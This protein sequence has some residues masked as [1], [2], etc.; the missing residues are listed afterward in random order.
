MPRLLSNRL[1]RAGLYVWLAIASL[2]V[3]GARAEDAVLLASTVPGYAPGMVISSTDRLSVPDGA[4]ATLLFQSGETLRLRGP[5]EGALGQQQPPA[6]TVGSVMF[7]DLFRMHGIDATVIGGT[8]S[9]VSARSQATL[10]DV[11]VDP[12]RSGT[13]C[14]EPATSVWI[15]RPAG[16]TGIYALRRKGNSRTLSWPTGAQR[17]EWPA[18]V[19]IED[20]SQFEITNGGAARTTVKFR[21]V[22]L[23]PG[24][25]RAR[26][27]AG[28]LAGCHDQ[29]D[30]ELRRF[31]RS[32]VSPE[33][34]ITTDHGRHP[35]Y[36]PGEPIGLTV[37]TST[38]GYVYCIATN[39]DGSAEPIFPAGAVDGAQLHGS[40]PL[41][42]PGRR[43]PNGLIATTATQQIRCW[44]ADRDIT[45]ELPHAV[46]GAPSTRLPDQF[47]SDLDGLFGRV[48]GTRTATDLLTIKA[49]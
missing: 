1:G 27:A 2:G 49:E 46:L 36:R 29:F 14:V 37:M 6:G 4:S 18:D 31:S 7:A 30:I 17:V 47:A 40:V 48:G 35:V 5:F 22:P 16:E 41:S 32:I 11:Q 3:E 9:T 43:Q 8:R 34:W 20:G 23:T 24:N 45:P 19:P 13:Y 15:T 42:I 21:N 12:E 25:G 44:F 28:L 39:N 38:D 26:I 33:V 10:D